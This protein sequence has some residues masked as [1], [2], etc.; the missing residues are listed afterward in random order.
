M[1]G[2]LAHVV[3]GRGIFTSWDGPP[4]WTIVY[5]AADKSE[6]AIVVSGADGAILSRFEG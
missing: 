2:R 5:R 6:L 3:L 4:T 1:V